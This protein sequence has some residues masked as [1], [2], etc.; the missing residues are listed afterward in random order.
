MVIIPFRRALF[1]VS[2]ARIDDPS[3]AKAAF[4]GA[5]TVN[6]SPVNK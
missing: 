5:N 1:D 6:P 2:L 4:V 3:F